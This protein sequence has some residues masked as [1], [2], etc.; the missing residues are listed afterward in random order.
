MFPGAAEE[1][2]SFSK[3]KIVVNYKEMKTKVIGTEG[4]V[5]GGIP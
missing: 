5:G 3:D 2:E 1:A 4:E